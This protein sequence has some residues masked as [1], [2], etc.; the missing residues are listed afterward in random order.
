MHSLKAKYLLTSYST[1]GM[2]PLQELVEACVSRGQTDFVLQGYKRYRVS[3]QRFSHKP[4][5]IEFILI[6]DTSKSHQ[7]SSA[8]QICDKIV[9]AEQTALVQHPEIAPGRFEQTVLFEGE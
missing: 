8:Q 6:V 1:D 3:S 5:N 4:V 9:Q 7:G 2:V